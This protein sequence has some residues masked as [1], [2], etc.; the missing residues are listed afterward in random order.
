MVKFDLAGRDLLSVC[1]ESI[2][3]LSGWTAIE[4][5]AITPSTKKMEIG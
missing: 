5:P 2:A 3:H 4:L 1:S